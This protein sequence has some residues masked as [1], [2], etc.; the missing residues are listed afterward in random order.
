MGLGVELVGRWPGS[1]VVEVAQIFLSGLGVE[2]VGSGL[3]T[4]FLIGS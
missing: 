1:Q 4:K 2:L 3:V